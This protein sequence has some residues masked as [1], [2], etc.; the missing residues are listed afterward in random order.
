MHHPSESK[1]NLSKHRRA[2]GPLT[3][4]SCRP[5]RKHIAV[6]ILIGRRASAVNSQLW[7]IVVVLIVIGLFIHAVP[8][9]IIVD[10]FISSDH[11]F[12]RRHNR[13]TG[14][15]IIVRLEWLRLDVS[16]QFAK[17]SRGRLGVNNVLVGWLQRWVIAIQKKNQL[18]TTLPITSILSSWHYQLK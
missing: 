17:G 13:K 14:I 6:D 10:I 3:W 1:T 2:S 11:Q 16:N 18:P 12:W 5:W 9:R 7:I 4:Q 15:L 8:F